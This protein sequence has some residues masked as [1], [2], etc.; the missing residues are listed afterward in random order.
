MNT[1]IE[2]VSTKSIKPHIKQIILSLY[3]LFEPH[4]QFF[5]FHSIIRS[6]TYNFFP[7]T[8]LHMN[9]IPINPLN[10]RTLSYQQQIIN[11]SL[12]SVTYLA[13]EV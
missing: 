12:E 13:L 6:I 3:A 10:I 9:S 5:I 11:C 7:L 1:L 2:E 8:K 4:M